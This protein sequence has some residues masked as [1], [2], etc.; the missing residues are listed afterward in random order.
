[1]LGSPVWLIFLP[2]AILVMGFAVYAVWREAP[3]TS[4]EQ[5]HGLARS[6]LQLAAISGLLLAPTGLH[7]LAGPNW[8]F[9]VLVIAIGLLAALG[10]HVLAERFRVTSR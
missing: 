10:A 6:G 3:K 9:G 7:L 2:A 1:M 5:R 4:P 8:Q